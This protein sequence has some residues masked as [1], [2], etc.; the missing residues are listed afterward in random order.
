MFSNYNIR[1]GFNNA[2]AKLNLQML[3]LLVL[4]GILIT[5]F[6]NIYHLPKPFPLS[7]TTLDIQ[8][9]II[10]EPFQT[11]TDQNELTIA[12]S[13]KYNKQLR[14]MFAANIFT[15]VSSDASH[16]NNQIAYLN[17]LALQTLP[18]TN[19]DDIIV[20]NFYLKNKDISHTSPALDQFV[21]FVLSLKE[22]R[23]ADFFLKADNGVD[24]N[25]LFKYNY[26]SD[27]NDTVDVEAIV[28]E[29]LP[30]NRSSTGISDNERA[31]YKSITFD[32]C[33]IEYNIKDI[34]KLTLKKSVILPENAFILPQGVTDPNTIAGQKEI[35]QEF[36]I[37]LQSDGL[38]TTLDSNKPLTLELVIAN[39]IPYNSIM[40]YKVSMR[41]GNATTYTNYL[42]WQ[43]YLKSAVVDKVNA[44]TFL[45]EKLSLKQKELLHD[46][47]NSIITP[48]FIV[49]NKISNLE[50][51]IQ[52]IQSTYNFNKLNNMASNIRFY[53]VT[54]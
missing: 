53:P 40:E 41:I 37:Y 33:T 11:E 23:A 5:C 9:S 47:Y 19:P 54:Q 51:S 6:V 3:I 36:V 43:M 35:L 42:T 21:A 52:N 28:T 14:A 49:D 25:I 26:K 10:N 50:K 27:F 4:C 45:A 2:C 30:E 1:T 46:K 48:M 29:R 44:N 18:K 8:Q 24:V 7:K 34:I 16:T 12:K 22:D 15:Q 32:K 20:T 31:S 38:L 13:V 39:F 17:L